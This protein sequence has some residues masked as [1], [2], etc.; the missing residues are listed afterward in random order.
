MLALP[1][2]VIAVVVMLV[3]PLARASCSTS[4]SR[5]TSRRRCSC[6]L[7]A[8]HVKRPLE[9]SVFPTLLARHD[10]VPARPECERHAACAAPRLCRHGHRE[11][12]PLRHRWIGPRRPCRVLDPYRHPVR[13]DH[14]RR[15]A[16]GR[17]GGPL[18]PRRT[19]WKA[20]GRRRRA[21]Q[22]AHHPRPGQAAAVA[23]SP[24]RPT[25]TGLWTAPRS[26]FAATP[27]PQSSSRR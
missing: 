1:L 21:L 23:R 22:P 6:L 15:R 11:L 3:I 16:R 27:S 24:T 7:T 10:R 26:S 20:D 25:S 14:Q 17:G 19:A 8:M 13:R 2:A 9:F 4:S 12:R 5:S 18:H